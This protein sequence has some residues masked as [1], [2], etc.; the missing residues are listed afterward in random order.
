MEI[1]RTLATLVVASVLV[2]ASGC[3]SK[4]EQLSSGSGDGKP[5]ASSTS[6][7]VGSYKG[8]IVT[9]GAKDDPAAKLAEGLMD[10]FSPEL[11]ITADNKFV[12]TM[13]GM[14]ISGS[15]VVAGS[16]LTMTPEKI[17]GMTPEEFKKQNAKNSMSQDPDMKP[18]K[19]T[20][21]KDGTITV[22]DDK[23]GG[24]ISFTKVVPKAIGTSTVTA[25]E[26]KYAGDYAAKIDEA[27]LKPEE[28]AMAGMANMFSLKLNVDNTF[29]MKVGM[30]VDGK[31][32]LDGDKIT[33]AADKSKG[34][35]GPDGKDPQ[36]RVE[37]DGSLVPIDEKGDAP[38]I[39]VKK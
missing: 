14:P 26:A 12:L 13:M 22:K 32:K 19:G 27:K 15:V 7:L 10:M 25:D 6:T 23:Q 39:F 35:K 28:K 24:N 16:D 37:K 3:S 30:T 5:G 29:E 36:F 4:T 20:V 34:F 2:L 31:W 38:F 1:M 17:M 33:L 18:L 11:E 8:K 9:E 21:G